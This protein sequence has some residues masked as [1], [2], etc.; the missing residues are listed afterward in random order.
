MDDSLAKEAEK[1]AEKGI[2]KEAE[3]REVIACSE[4][5]SQMVWVDQ[6][7]WLVLFR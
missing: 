4:S 2:E 1:E 5:H 6:L 7:Q 3:M